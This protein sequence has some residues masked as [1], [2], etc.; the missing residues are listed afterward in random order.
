MLA[1]HKQ[2]YAFRHLN[3]LLAFVETRRVLV[4][5]VKFADIGQGGLDV[6]DTS[7]AL[8]IHQLVRDVEQDK[9][10][11]EYPLCISVGMTSFTPRTQD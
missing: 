1:L 8:D 11:I 7:P 9:L 5:C 3:K 6:L 10:G 4:Q 2:F